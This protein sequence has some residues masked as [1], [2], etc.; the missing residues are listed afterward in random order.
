MNCILYFA[1]M[2]QYRI[3]YNKI[4]ALMSCT[5][6]PTSTL[7]SFI[8]F[9]IHCVYFSN[10]YVEQ[11][12]PLLVQAQRKLV[13]RIKQYDGPPA[14]QPHFV[15]AMEECGKPLQAKKYVNLQLKLQ[16]NTEDLAKIDP[17]AHIDPNGHN[18]YGMDTV[19]LFCLLINVY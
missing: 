18:I 14:P 1:I 9:M 17:G 13:Q 16:L 11:I 10:R 3:L 7:H 19:F 12:N 15:T 4:S 8:P 5:I 6:F 2:W